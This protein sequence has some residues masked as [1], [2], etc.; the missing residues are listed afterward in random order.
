MRGLSFFTTDEER[1]R[2]Q[3]LL[4]WGLTDSY[5]HLNP[6]KQAFTWWD[7]R[8]GAWERNKGL[9]IDHI[10]VTQPL[11]ERIESGDV[12][13]MVRGQPQPSDHVPVMLTL[14]D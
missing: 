3:A 2:Y 8:A 10:L 7:Y 11:V 6:D 12:H 14:A 1:G 13:T 5:R 9:R 4:D